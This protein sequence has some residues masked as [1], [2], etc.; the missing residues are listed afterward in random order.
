M[1]YRF[2]LLDRDARIVT[3]ADLEA[4]DDID[5]VRQANEMS[6]ELW[7]LWCGARRVAQAIGEADARLAAH[8]AYTLRQAESSQEALS[9]GSA[10]LQR[11]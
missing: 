3:G 2:Y 6:A 4:A 1:H 7:E 8:A 9:P 11:M 10:P 5:A